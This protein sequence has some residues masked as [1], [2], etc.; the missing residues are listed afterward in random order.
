MSHRNFQLIIFLSGSSNAGGDCGVV[1]HHVATLWGLLLYNSFAHE[2][3]LDLWF[4]F[5]AKTLIY[6]NSAMNPYLYNAM[7]RRFRVAVQRLFSFRSKGKAKMMKMLSMVVL[8]LANEF[9]IAPMYTL[10]C[11]GKF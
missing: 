8:V 5:F 3:W 2:V 6:F 4:V 11:T 1:C 10:A 9:R 7:S